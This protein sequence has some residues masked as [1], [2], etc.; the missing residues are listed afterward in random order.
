MSAD[1]A[2]V[3]VSAVVLAMAGGGCSLL[4]SAE[5]PEF[6]C[7]SAEPSAC[8]SGTTCDLAAGRCVS[9]DA[10]APPVD[11][12]EEEEDASDEDVRDADADADAGPLPLGSQ[13]RVDA[14]CESRLCGSSTIL[15]TTITQTT[16]PI[17][18][19]PC[20]NSSECAPS[21]VCFNG[22][23][24][25]GY[26]V[27]AA[28]AKR[29]PPATGGKGGGTLCAANDE[30]RSGACVGSPK[31]CLD[32]CCTVTECGAGSVCRLANVSA[33]APPH[34]IWVCAAPTATGVKAP[35]VTCTADSECTTD[36]C[37]GFATK[38]CRPP[39]SNTASCRAVPGFESGHC[40]YGISGGSDSFKFCFL[41]TTGTDSPA[42]AACTT[43]GTCQSDYCDAEL[44]KCANLC[45]RDGDC[46]A[47]ETCRPSAVNTPYLR[48][49]PKP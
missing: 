15:T 13:C 40:L 6:T 38:Q 29:Q 4:V 1:L 5:V 10:G 27:P 39:C 34:D 28:L 9:G 47:N 16:G 14:D 31:R 18:T 17:C 23:T 42:G 2:K 36:A 30:C 26:C 19:T 12:G 49:V 41:T 24:G 35:G 43:D 11:S 46:A 3:V 21:F 8:P 33:P 48:C 22:G 44:K 32:T 20:C 45:A 37:L 7:A 25:G